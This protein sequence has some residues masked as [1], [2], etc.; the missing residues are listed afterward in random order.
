MTF[1]RPWPNETGLDYFDF[2]YHSIDIDLG[3]WAS[4]NPIG[5]LIHIG[6]V[7]QHKITGTTTSQ[8]AVRKILMANPTVM[9]TPSPDP[10]WN[11][12]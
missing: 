8:D 2:R 1:D 5:K 11:R 12:R 10:K 7:L 9:I 6:E 4:P 3:N